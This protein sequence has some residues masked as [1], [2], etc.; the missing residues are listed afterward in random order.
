M[1]VYDEQQQ[2]CNKQ[3]EETWKKIHEIT[4]KKMKT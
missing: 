2:I 1:N 4:R 3:I